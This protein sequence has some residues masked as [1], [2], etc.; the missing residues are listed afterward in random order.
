M[1]KTRKIIHIDMDYFFAQVE[2]KANPSLKNKP[3]SIT[4]KLLT[5]NLLN[6]KHIS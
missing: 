2:E 6:L 5:L 3:F 1:S 4:Q